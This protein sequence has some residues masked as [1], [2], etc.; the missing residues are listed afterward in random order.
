MGESASQR[1]NPTL[2]PVYSGFSVGLN[3]LLIHLPN[4]STYVKHIISL[5]KN[6]YLTIDSYY[7]S[8]ETRRSSIVVNALMTI[9]VA[10][11]AI[12]TATSMVGIDPTN[13]NATPQQ[14]K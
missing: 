9:F 7:E 14:S 13:M 10:G 12:M 3:I 5:G 11:I 1:L 2:S 6:R 8:H 4:I